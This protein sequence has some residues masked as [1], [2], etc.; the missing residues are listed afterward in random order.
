MDQRD[1]NEA[2]EES[3]IKRIAQLTKAMEEQRALTQ[4]KLDQNIQ[5]D[6]TI[7]KVLKGIDDL[8]R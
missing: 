5:A 2:R 4:A 6:A 7:L 1:V 3:Q 8:V